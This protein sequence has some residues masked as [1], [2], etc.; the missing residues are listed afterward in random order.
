MYTEWWFHAGKG[1][2][3]RPEGTAPFHHASHNTGMSLGDK[4]PNVPYYRSRAVAQMLCP[5]REAAVNQRS[6][7]E[8]TLFETIIEKPKFKGAVENNG[9]AYGKQLT[10]GCNSMRA[11]S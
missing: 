4:Q 8:K 2:P 6:P 5:R 9:D 7:F 3:R 11:T 1:K 10:E